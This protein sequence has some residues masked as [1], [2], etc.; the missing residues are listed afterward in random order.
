LLVDGDADVG[1]GDSSD[2]DALRAVVRDPNVSRS[3][4][5]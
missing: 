3:G 5:L 4:R 2:G 1:H